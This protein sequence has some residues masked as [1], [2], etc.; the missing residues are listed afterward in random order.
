[1]RAWLGILTTLVAPAT[2]TGTS[3]PSSEASRAADAPPGGPL[4][5]E[6]RAQP[7]ATTGA[8][9]P[10]DGATQRDGVAPTTRAA[11]PDDPA[12]AQVELFADLD[13]IRAYGCAHLDQWAGVRFEGNGIVASFTGD[14]PTHQAALLALVD[15][16]AA[17][18]V[19]LAER[20]AQALEAVRQ[21]IEAIFEDPARQGQM[22]SLGTTI[23]AV[24]VDVRADARDLAEELVT[25][26]GD[27][28]RVTL[29]L[30]PLGTSE[31][32]T[33]RCPGRPA[34]QVVDGLQA[35]VEL[36]GPVASGADFR[37]RVVLRNGGTAPVV[38]DSGGPLAALVVDDRGAVVGSYDGAIAGVGIGVDLAPGATT[39][40]TIV[41]ATASCDPALGDALPPGRYGVIVA[42]ETYD[43]AGR[44]TVDPAGGP[45]IAGPGVL[46]VAP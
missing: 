42:V 11:A 32:P 26:Y 7:S 24:E 13:R 19:V 3:S 25:R 31:P 30:L 34:G 14:L 43:A 9:P 22:R 29:G 45:I 39:T 41:G 20:T 10:A 23:D 18:R 44:A 35:S 46:E 1:M 15:H 28:V 12:V 17:I 21:E 40:L 33:A 27:Q 2:T 8:A 38:F 6:C 36:D 16:P 5:G 37:G 4:D